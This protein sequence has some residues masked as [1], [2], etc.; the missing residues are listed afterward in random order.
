MASAAEDDWRFGAT[1]YAWLP[2]IRGTTQFPSG[3]AG[4][5][6]DLSTQDVLDKLD[7]AFMGTFEARR[8]QWGGLAD[9]VYSDLSATKSATRDFT[10]GGL[11]PVAGV[12]SD[13]RVG[14]KTNLLTLAGTYTISETKTNTTALIA[15]ARMI[16]NDQTLDWSFSSGPILGVARTGSA[17]ATSTNWDAIVG[18][19]GRARVYEDSRW[20]WPYHLDIG[21]GESNSTIN[22]VGGVAYAF[23]FG[24]VGLAWRYVDYRFKSSES[25][26]SLKF[27]GLALGVAFRF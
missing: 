21:T 24:E 15:G 2:S 10:V 26:Q 6:I 9:W 13:L 5:S 22:A 12:T 8:G 7:M 20:F 3:G 27:S 19:R 17:G 4:P 14:V 1:V 16:K 11:P 23:D 25:I 18:V